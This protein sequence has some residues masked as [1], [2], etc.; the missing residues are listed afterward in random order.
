MISFLLS[1]PIF[2]KGSKIKNRKI[3]EGKIFVAIAPIVTPAADKSATRMADK[4]RIV[5]ELS[6]IALE[7]LSK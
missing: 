4:S 5:L 2:C 1:T 3:G 6:R 7:S